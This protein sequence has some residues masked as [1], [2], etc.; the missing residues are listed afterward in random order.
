M[1]QFTCP[2]KSQQNVATDNLSTQSHD[3]L[4]MYFDKNLNNAF[5][6]STARVGGQ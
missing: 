2:N 3:E 1:N 4:H 6:Q 5:K